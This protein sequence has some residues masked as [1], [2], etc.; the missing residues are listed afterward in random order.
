MQ[1]VFFLLPLLS[2]LSSAVS[3]PPGC[4]GIPHKLEMTTFSWF[5][6]THNLDCVN[7][8]F[9]PDGT[10]CW[11]ANNTLCASGS[12]DCVCTAYC[13]TGTESVA[14]QPLGYG[15]PDTI[16]ITIDGQNCAKSSPTGFRDSELGEGNY[17]CGS[18][19]QIISFTG[20]SNAHK[21]QT[22]TVVFNAYYAP[23]VSSCNG[24]VPQYTASFPLIC[25]HDSGF[26]AT[27][28]AKKLPVHL[29][30]SGLF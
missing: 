22:G 1:T 29:V 6:S 21:G 17:D 11:G 30:F 23:G 13:E 12:E 26:N 5:N 27:C 10:V 19:A 24:Q 4:T 28:R 25:T 8:N 15:P 2:G 16:N 9:P 3:I 18:A 20:D 14:Y 7:P